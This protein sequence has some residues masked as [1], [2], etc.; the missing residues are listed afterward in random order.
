MKEQA[1]LGIASGIP[2]AIFQKNGDLV[3]LAPGQPGKFGEVRAGRLLLDGDIISP[4]NGEAI[5]MRRR[6]AANGI[7]TVAA[8]RR[9]HVAVSAV[10]LPLD[11]DYPGFV[12]E[13][14]KDVADALVRAKKAE[15]AVRQEAVR[16]AARRAA[17]R[18]SGK[19]PQV[20]VLL[21]ED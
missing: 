5:I 16:L 4:A 8:D 6:I 12:A 11:E 21:L 19:K 20:Q 2:K 15:P 1:R 17:T 7:V 18:W 9:G 13:A 14:Q 3:R 10:G